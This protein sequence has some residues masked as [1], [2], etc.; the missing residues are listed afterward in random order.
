MWDELPHL[1]AVIQYIGQPKEKYPNVYSVSGCFWGARKNIYWHIFGG[2][3]KL[4]SQGA[5]YN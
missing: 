2:G 4:G 3:Q 1:K 5:T